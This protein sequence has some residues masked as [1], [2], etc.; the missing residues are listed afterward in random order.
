LINSA[1]AE[2]PKRIPL[3]ATYRFAGEGEPNPESC[4]VALARHGRQTQAVD[5]KGAHFGA[6]LDLSPGR[7]THRHPVAPPR[8]LA[9]LLAGCGTALILPLDLFGTRF[10][11]VPYLAHQS[12]G[13]N[14]R[15]MVVFDRDSNIDRQ[16]Q[17]AV[18]LSQ[19]R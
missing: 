9:Y 4:R 2:R 10:G 15:S 6:I 5:D 1:P 11:E 12:G 18:E 16:R 19:Q 3:R 7:A 14:R 17:P 8:S 13:W